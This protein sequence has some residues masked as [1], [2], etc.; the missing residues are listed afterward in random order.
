[1]E[2]RGFLTRLGMI[3]LVPL[4]VPSAPLLSAPAVPQGQYRLERTLRRDLFDGKAITIRRSWLV[5]FKPMD[6]G[7]L[8]VEGEQTAS[9]VDAPPTL[10]ALARLE[11]QRKVN[12]PLPLKLSATGRIVDQPGDGTLDPLPEAVID[13]AADFVAAR[14]SPSAVDINMREFVALLS[15]RQMGWLSQ[16]PRDLF[17]PVPR[18]RSA[19]REIALPDGAQGRVDLREVAAANP[20]TGLLESYM[21]EAITSVGD[22]SRSATETWRLSPAV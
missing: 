18:D 10:A 13:A 3:G 11:E 2:R 9:T 4:V 15:Q 19:A 21:R 1:M 8:V 14:S 17:F 7:G 12:G 20:E 5:R 6:G 16:L 22:S